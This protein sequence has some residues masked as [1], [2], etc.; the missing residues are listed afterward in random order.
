MAQKY[1]Q[2]IGRWGETVASYYL[3]QRG[4]RVLERNVRTG[5]GEIDLI[6]RQ[7]AP[8][9]GNAPKCG[10]AP[11]R[12]EVLVFVEVKTRTN[13]QFGLPEE[14]VDARKLEHLFRAAEAYLEEHQELAALEWRIDV[15][16]IQGKPGEKAEDVL[17]EH[18][19]NISA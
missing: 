6:A 17:I 13:Q 4:F 12:G 8:R 16:A 2:K 3:E 1:K 5:R 15:I 14:A 18:F 11:N 19:E 9:H 7:A 10:E